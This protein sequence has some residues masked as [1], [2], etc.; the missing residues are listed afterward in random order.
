MKIRSSIPKTNIRKDLIIGTSVTYKG[1]DIGKISDID[2]DGI[3]EIEIYEEYADQIFDLINKGDKRF[4]CSI[5]EME[6]WK[7]SKLEG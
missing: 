2:D 7:D 4:S 3:T 1:V 5:E 6:K